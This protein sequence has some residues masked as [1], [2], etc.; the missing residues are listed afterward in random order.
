[1]FFFTYECAVEY[2]GFHGLFKVVFSVQ[3]H[4]LPP[5]VIALSVVS[6]ELWSHHKMA[7]IGP[8]I[9]TRGCRIR[10]YE[11]VP[12]FI[13]LLGGIIRMGLHLCFL[14]AYLY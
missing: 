11:M 13:R 8:D 10:E 4:F 3:K 6:M 7:E 2:M 1:M 5:L 9:R 14:H 12:W